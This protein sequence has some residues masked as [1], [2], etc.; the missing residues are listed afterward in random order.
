MIAARTFG[1]V[2]ERG[3][4]FPLGANVQ[5]GGVNFS[6]FSRKATLAELLLFDRVDAGE[7]Q[8]S[9]KGATSAAANA[10]LALRIFSRILR[11]DSRQTYFFGFRLRSAR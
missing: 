9:A 1:D 8:L 5:D 3:K 7:R 4:P 11:P 2:I 6:V 10:S